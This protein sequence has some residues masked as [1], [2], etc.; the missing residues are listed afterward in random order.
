MVGQKLSSGQRDGGSAVTAVPFG[1]ESFELPMRIEP[2]KV[3]Y[4]FAKRVAD[5]FVSF[6]LLLLLLP[7][8][9]VLSIAVKLSGPG[10][11]FYKSTRIGL[12]GRPFTFIKFR[13]MRTDADKQLQE[14]AQQNEKDGP[15][16][17]MK[18][19]P[20][21]TKIGAFLRKYSLD[22]LPQLWSVFTGEMS[23]VGPRP[24]I[25][26]EVAQYDD[27]AIQRLTVK[28]G[29]TCYWQIMGRSRLSFE[30]W[31]DLDHKYLRDMSFWTDCMILIKTPIA[32]V[33][34]D[35]AY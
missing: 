19:D 4:A 21:I 27:Y 13:S 7:L 26:R 24:P 1:S 18:S 32:V 17:K 2:K 9:I 15:I 35:G 6:S 12:C 33:K 11:V 8:F 29:I 31:M 28:P 23:I 5:I 16:F 30:E 20:R 3:R 22:E 25:P 10:P 34:G 14:L